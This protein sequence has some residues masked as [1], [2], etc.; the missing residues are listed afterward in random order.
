MP[1][2]IVRHMNQ[3]QYPRLVNEIPRGS[4]RYKKT[5]SLRVAS[6]RSNSSLKE[7][8]GI[9]NKPR[10]LDGERANCLAQIAGTVLLLKRSFSFIVRSTIL[11]WRFYQD[12]D[13]TVID[14]LIP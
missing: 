9:L 12:N 1:Q 2:G 13:Q 8:I 14:K 4:R 7:D 6:E 5:K 11:M 3:K 10:V